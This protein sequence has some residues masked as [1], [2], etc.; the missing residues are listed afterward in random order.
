MEPVIYLTGSLK[1]YWDTA[2]TAERKHLAETGQCFS[3]SPKKR[4][5]RSGKRGFLRAGRRGD[6]DQRGL[7]PIRRAS[8]RYG[9][10]D[11]LDSSYSFCSFPN[12]RLSQVRFIDDAVAAFARMAGLH[13]L[14]LLPRP[15]RK[16]RRHR[17]GGCRRPHLPRQAARPFGLTTPMQCQSKLW[18][19]LSAT[20]GASPPGAPLAS[21]KG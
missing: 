7:R 17:R 18:A 15:V 5:P 9:S 2:I 20:A 10:N 4:K 3:G 19:K 14:G 6:S 13:M 1:F 21:K 11:L 12:G 16:A 8:P